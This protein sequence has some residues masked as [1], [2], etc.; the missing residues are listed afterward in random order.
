[1]TY[2]FLWTPLLMIAVPW[3]YVYRTYVKWPKRQPAATAKQT[4]PVFN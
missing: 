1:M 3:K 2:V 4:A